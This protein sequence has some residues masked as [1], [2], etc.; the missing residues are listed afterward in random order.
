VSRMLDSVVATKKIGLLGGMSWESSALYYKLI[1]EGVRDRLG[2]L[3]SAA[4]VMASVDF[5]VVE[6]FQAAGRWSEAAALLV[7][8]AQGLVAAGAECVVLC[9]NTMHK[10][11]TP[12]EAAIDVPLIHIGD[13]TA[14]AIRQA[15]L[16][17][18]ALLGTRFTME[19]PFY[20]ERA[21]THGVE[22][23]VPNARDRAIV[24]EIIYNE[25]VVGVVRDESRDHYREIVHRLV[26]EGAEGVILGCTEIELLIDQRELS[27]PTFAST[28][29]HARAAVDF[30]M[31]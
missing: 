11:A 28:T 8:E 4:C 15:G 2:G 10:V 24:N 25:L 29:L 14:A 27:V 13:V 5:S 20:R 30:A 21:A 6:G 31:T 23:M 18:V 3:H 9:T 1:N 22:T 7:A 17:K 26:D 16:A 19:E 12:I